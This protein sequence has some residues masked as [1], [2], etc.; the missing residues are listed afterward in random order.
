[1]MIYK[2]VQ[3]LIILDNICLMMIFNKINKKEDQKKYYNMMIK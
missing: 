1:M 3:K 2:M